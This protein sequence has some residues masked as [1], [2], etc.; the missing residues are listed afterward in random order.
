MGLKNNSN[1]SE[2]VFSCNKELILLK[3]LD[4]EKEGFLLEQGQRYAESLMKAGMYGNI[5]LAK[6]RAISQLNSILASEHEEHL[7]AWMVNADTKERV[8]SLWWAQRKVNKTVWIY[9]IE[10][11]ESQRRRGYA[12]KALMALETWGLEV[13]VP[14]I[15]L[16]VFAYN[17]G[18]EKLYREMGFLDVS[19]HMRKELS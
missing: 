3:M 8:G 14:S 7:Y 17:S 5:E 13:G 2:S 19:K 15:S 18:A 10:V 1:A 12:R 11:L 9:D 6:E 4:V 16:N